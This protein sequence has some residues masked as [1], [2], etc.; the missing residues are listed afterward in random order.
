MRAGL[1]LIPDLAKDH[2]EKGRT[3]L[4]FFFP[5]SIIQSKKNSNDIPALL[6]E[7]ALTGENKKF[8]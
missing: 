5:K 1:L 7:Q 4:K 3:L 6:A 8:Q 2:S